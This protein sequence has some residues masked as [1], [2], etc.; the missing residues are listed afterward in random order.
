MVRSA[1]FLV[2]ALSCVAPR[3]DL[4]DQVAVEPSDPPADTAGPVPTAGIGP[5]DTENLEAPTALLATHPARAILVFDSP[6]GSV[7]AGIQF[8]DAMKHAQAR[9]T[10]IACV[11]PAASMAASMAAVI[12]QQCDVRVMARGAALMFHGVSIGGSS[13]NQQ[14]FERLTREM[15]GWNHMLAIIASMKLR[16]SLAAY[17]ARVREGDWWLSADEALAIGATDLTAS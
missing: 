5:I 9:G 7:N 15:A 14:D 10:S 11:I 3:L 6:G 16:I 17:E 8:L 4:R 13:G 2:L 12:F 1:L